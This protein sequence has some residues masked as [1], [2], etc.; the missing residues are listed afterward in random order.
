MG[1]ECLLS[2]IAFGSGQIQ[3][4]KAGSRPQMKAKAKI[5]VL[6]LNA[7]NDLPKACGKKR[8]VDWSCLNNGR[9]SKCC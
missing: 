8:F 3:K 7:E 5:H 4:V 6:L 9:I 1:K 2:A